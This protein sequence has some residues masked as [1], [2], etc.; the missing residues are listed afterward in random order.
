MFYKPSSGGMWDPTLLYFNDKYYMLSMFLNPE[1]EKWDSMWVAKSED[2]VHFDDIGCVLTESVNVCKMFAYVHGDKC[3]I[4]HGSFSGRPD[5][6]NDTLCF[7]ESTDMKNWNHMFDNH[8]DPKWYNPVGRWDH[9]YVVQKEIGCSDKG[10]WGYVVAT[11]R[12][13]L[14]AAFGML[15]SEDGFNWNILPPPV[16]EWGDVPKVGMLEVGGCEKIG[17]KYYFIGGVGGYAKNGGYSMY[18]FVSDS[19]TGPFRPDME[20]FRL[21]G[22]DRLPN[23]VFTQNLA[24]FCRGKD[25]E[26]LISNAFDAGFPTKIWLLPTRKAVVDEKGHLRL[27]YWEQNELAKGVELDLNLKNAIPLFMEDRSV[28]ENGKIPGLTPPQ[29]TVEKTDSVFIATSNMTTGFHLD[30]I[31]ALVMLDKKYDFT[32]GVILE[33]F[34][35]ADKNPPDKK[36]EAWPMCWRPSTIGFYLEH[37]DGITGTAITIEVDHAYHRKSFIEIITLDGKLKRETIDVSGEGCATLTGVTPETKHPFKLFI[38]RD[39][40]ELYVDNL[41]V[42]S[43]IVMKSTSGRI[44]FVLQNAQIHFEDLKIFEM[45][46]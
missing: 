20:A 44:G 32:K 35:T 27:G 16:I 41:L 22:F 8:P 39:M 42:Q 23:R 29:L 37:E 25:G 12:L 14:N 46:F 38:R 13:E 36:T 30:D 24:A 2:G 28:G 1:T 5:T 7:Y 9:M 33:G 43:F 31:N 26:I 40:F 21:C 45:N 6:D 34:L 18:T 10:Y 3:R 15:E 19:P 11:P 4:N 17:D